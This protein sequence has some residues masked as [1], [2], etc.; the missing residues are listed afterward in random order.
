MRGLPMRTESVLLLASTALAGPDLRPLF[1]GL[2]V[3]NFREISVRR[4]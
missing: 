2:C 3:A 1:N 4:P